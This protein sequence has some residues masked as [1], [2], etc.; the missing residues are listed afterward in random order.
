M[1]KKTN[2]L[3]FR[4]SISSLWK[5]K[6]PNFYKFINVLR[7]ENILYLELQKRKLSILD[8]KWTRSRTHIWVYDSLDVSIIFKQE[9]FQF[10]KKT[11]NAIKLMETYSLPKW[12]LLKILLDKRFYIQ[13]TISKKKN[14]FF[15]LSCFLIKDYGFQRVCKIIKILSYFQW[16]QLNFILKS[17]L[18][19]NT[20]YAFFIRRPLLSTIRW[21]LGLN[22][23]WSLCFFKILSVYLENIVFYTK[24]ICINVNV[25]NI[26]SK[27]GVIFQ[28][29]LR[30]TFLYQL[31]TL[32]SVYNNSQ[33]LSEFIAIQLKKD[34]NHRRLLRRIILCIENF[35]TSY[36]L[37][38][39]GFQ[40][41]VTG[42]L[43]GNMRKSK[44]Q[45]ILGKVSLQTLDS[46][47]SYTM[48][49]S[50]TKFGLISNKLWLFYG[51]KQI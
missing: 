24:Q 42:K 38:F 44:Y 31:L 37:S 1:T 3:L 18:I 36:D 2:S 14:Y 26:W 11:K 33:I 34:K 48:N 30:D 46:I 6:S 49:V 28:Y 51:N 12:L 19:L 41:R 47:I 40:L 8:I 4:L 16:I 21:Q 50:Y 45:Y 23:V 35:W 17:L 5:N 39:S 27:K 7:L 32:S 20:V 9:V 22:K 29:F 15:S 25:S 43:N 13:K 10:Y